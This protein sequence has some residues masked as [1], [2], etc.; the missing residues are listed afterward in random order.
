MSTKILFANYTKLKEKLVNRNSEN[1]QNVFSIV[2]K[3]NTASARESENQLSS[4]NL[5]Y[6]DILKNAETVSFN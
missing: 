2:K 4:Q 6:K 1:I 5:M 3:A